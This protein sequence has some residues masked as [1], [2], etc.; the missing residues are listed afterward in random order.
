[1]VV[2]A[3][4]FNYGI[5]VNELL[6]SEE[7]VVKPLG[8]H[9]RHLETYS[10]ATI[11]GDGKAALILDI[12]GI[13]KSMKLK[14]VKE[15]I[16][17][18]QQIE[19]LLNAKDTQ[20]L[21]LVHNGN[22]EQFAIP[23]G[24][25][26]R[27]EKIHKDDPIETSGKMALKYR[28]G[29]LIVLSIEDVANVKPRKEVEHPYVVIFQYRGK[30]IGVIVSHIVDILETDI[31]IDGE[32]FRQPGIAGSAILR[33]KI[34]LLL[35]LYGLASGSISEE[36]T[37]AEAE[38]VSSS[39]LQQKNTILIVEDSKFFLNQ[40]KGFTEDAGYNVVTALD[41]LEGLDMLNSDDQ[42]DLILTDIEMPNMDG[43][44]FSKEVRNNMRF[45]E[46]PI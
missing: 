11:L 20:S 2:S 35:D 40:I 17:V 41:G 32:T 37:I 44:Q 9:L 26:S 15:E 36:E 25:I 3:G 33:E 13:S 5:I 1:V 8:T 23:L 34:T 42:I 30:E 14:P 39:K 21:I 12:I 4:S 27:V 38:V 6:D 10:G 28:G 31:K 16:K 45:K 18:E 24:L 19:D 22:E 43:L 29:N 7:I 46:M